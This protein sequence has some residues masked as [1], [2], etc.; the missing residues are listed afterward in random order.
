MRMLNSLSSSIRKAANIAPFNAGVCDIPI[1]GNGDKTCRR[2]PDVAE[3][4]Y[5]SVQNS[6]RSTLSDLRGNASNTQQSRRIPRHQRGNK[7]G[8]I[9]HR[10]AP[11]DNHFSDVPS[12][13]ARRLVENRIYRSPTPHSLV[14]KDRTQ[15]NKPGAI[16]ISSGSVDNYVTVISVVSAIPNP[17]P[18]TT[19]YPQ[20]APSLPFLLVAIHRKHQQDQKRPNTNP[21]HPPRPR[22]IPPHYALKH[23]RENKFQTILRRNQ[24]RILGARAAR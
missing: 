19:A 6:I 12:K 3:A 4:L 21:P 9:L 20:T 22:A 11:R 17:T 10:Q 14:P 2:D 8:D 13:A 15:I 18:M 16:L 5:I 23:R 24:H 7:G 1:A